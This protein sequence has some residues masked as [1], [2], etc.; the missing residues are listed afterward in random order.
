[1]Y[2]V[3]FFFSVGNWSSSQSSRPFP[4]TVQRQV[5]GGSDDCCLA[6]WGDPVPRGTV[7]EVWGRLCCHTG[8]AL[9]LEWMGAGMLLYLHSTQDG[10]PQRRTRPVSAGL[11]GETLY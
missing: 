2:M 9:G 1:M 5:A 11:T 7:A 4:H 8:G 6:Q 3:L 10:P